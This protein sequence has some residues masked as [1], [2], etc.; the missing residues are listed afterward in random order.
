M[1]LHPAVFFF[2]GSNSRGGSAS[3]CCSLFRLPGVLVVVAPVIFAVILAVPL[4][5]RHLFSLSDRVPDPSEVAI[6]GLE[7]DHAITFE[8]E[9]RGRR[10]VPRQ[11]VHLRPAGTLVPD[12]VSQ[13]LPALG[14][15]FGQS[16]APW[17][18]G[19][20]HKLVLWT[21]VVIAIVIASTADRSLQVVAVL[22]GQLHESRESRG[23]ERGFRN[24]DGPGMNVVGPD[25]DATIVG[26]HAPDSLPGP[27]RRIEQNGLPGGGVCV[28]LHWV[29]SR[30]PPGH[31]GGRVVGDPAADAHEA[32][33]NV[34]GHHAGFQDKGSAPGHGIDQGQRTGRS[35]AVFMVVVTGRHY[36]PDLVVP[37]RFQQEA[38]CHGL[39][40]GRLVD[41]SPR[42]VPPLVETPRWVQAPV[43]GEARRSSVV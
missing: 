35:V 13:A 9:S 24:V 21:C 27:L 38:R 33:G 12:K 43:D 15:V 17:G 31:R 19:S 16:D 42:A 20:H 18:V 14:N 7:R 26:L 40:H 5:L 34:G 25:P 23:L 11:D 8:L 3:G 4:L 10:L 28:V 2:G 32:G 37:S 41:G 22:V 6:A 29:A 39:L 1:E 30:L 36:C